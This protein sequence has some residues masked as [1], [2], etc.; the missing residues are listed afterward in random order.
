MPV[1]SREEK[2]LYGKKQRKPAMEVRD[3]HFSYGKNRI[4]KGVSLKIR[5][6]EITTIMGANG[7]GK[8]TLF[9]LMTKNLVP[10]RGR[11]F[12]K[13]RNIQNLNIKEFAKRVSIVHQYNTASDDITVEQLVS[14]GR[15]PHRKMMQEASEEDE[16]LINWAMDVTNISRFRNREVAR[17]SGGQRQRVWIAMALAQ[18]TKILFL[19]E[20]TTYLDIRY[21][22]EILE[23]VRR[24]NREFGI[25]IIMVLHDVNQAIAFSDQII[26]LKSGKVAVQ[27]NPQD[28]IDGESIHKLYGIHLEVAEVEGRKFVVASERLEKK[29]EEVSEKTDL[30]T[31]DAAP[32]E[33]WEEGEDDEMEEHV[34]NSSGQKKSG[35]RMVRSVWALVGVLCLILGC[36]GIVLPILPTT[37]FFLATLFCFAKSSERLYRWFVHTQLYH[38]YLENYVKHKSMTVKN[39]A[40]I[41]LTVTVIMAIG[42]FMMKNVPVGRICLAVV[43]IAHIIVF[44]FVIKTISPEEEERLAREDQGADADYREENIRI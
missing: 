38:K 18:N 43:W 26:G 32:A 34:K 39:K 4:L 1:E 22:I 24:L 12:L 11:I 3:L 17:L 9:N 14:F 19:D 20:P 37:P 41:M 30:Q 15:T 2:N 13:G 23:L 6:G 33:E 8:S 25:T 27:G 44:V 10:D 7:C 40:T 29:S 16:Q 28:V 21:Q 36:V 35:S 31:A 5:E 42:F